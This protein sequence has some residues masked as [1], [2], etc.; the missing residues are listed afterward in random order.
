IWSWANDE[1][2][3]FLFANE[4]RGLVIRHPYRAVTGRGLRIDDKESV[5][6][7]IY[8]ERPLIETLSTASPKGR[9]SARSASYVEIYRYD[10]LGI[11]FE[12][13]D[14]RVRAIALFPARPPQAGE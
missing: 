3:V 10:E 14:K 6:K 9:G 8:P 2:L 4:V 12:I 7:D 1:V 13:Q 11:G 5:L